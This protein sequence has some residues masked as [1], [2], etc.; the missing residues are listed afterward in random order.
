MS[1]NKLGIATLALALPACAAAMQTQTAPLQAT[2]TIRGEGIS[3]TVEFREVDNASGSGAHTMAAGVKAVEITA[4]VTGLT[5]GAHGFHLHQTGRCDPD[6]KAAGGH[7]DP[8][9][10][11]MNNPDTN[12][13]FH[14]GD[15]P[16]LIADANG[17]ATLKTITTRVTLS[18]GPLSLFDE[19]GTA[20]IVHKDPD[21]GITGADGSGVSGGARIACGVVERR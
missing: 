21:Q 11:G 19:D 6:F 2:A 16:N 18:P 8:G 12:H 1:M 13:P 10:H 15:V 3:G 17:R 7:F 5:P 20:V 14:M 4:T 9:P